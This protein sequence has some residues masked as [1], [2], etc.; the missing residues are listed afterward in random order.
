MIAPAWP[1]ESPGPARS[2]RPRAAAA[3]T[4]LER[5]PPLL[6]D[7]SFT[8]INSKMSFNWFSAVG[9]ICTTACAVETQRASV[10]IVAKA[11]LA[12]DAL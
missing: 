12:P 4:A 3:R 5:D 9:A 11:A 8:L 10:R 7:A 1:K 6:R 2:V